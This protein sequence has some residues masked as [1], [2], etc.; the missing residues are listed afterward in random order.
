MLLGALA[1]SLGDLGGW[2]RGVVVDWLPFFLVMTAYDLAR[3]GADGWLAPTH[4]LPQAD[5]DRWLFGGRVPTAWLQQHLHQPGHVRWFEVA[6][7]VV[8]VSHFFVTPLLAAALWLRDRWRS[9]R[10]AAALALLTLLGSLTFVAFPAAPPW[11]A[12]QHGLIEP[13]SRLIPQ[14]WTWSGVGAETGVVGTGYRYANEVAAV[15][16]LH[17]ALALLVAMSVWP[18]HWW[19]RLLV[20]AYPLAMALAIVYT[21]EHYVADVLLGWL[22]AVASF[23]A[24]SWLASRV[25][26][27]RTDRRKTIIPAPSR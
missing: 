26:P 11:M 18:R 20:G 12:S 24:V 1:L 9:R 3:G 25:E 13:V 22:Y 2:L 10:F 5:V 27:R 14:L 17:A 15:P 19:A 7:F 4:F 23:R 21:G 6:A 16:S 8:Y